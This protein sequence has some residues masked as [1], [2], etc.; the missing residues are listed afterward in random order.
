MRTSSIKHSDKPAQL[1]FSQKP[2]SCFAR[3]NQRE[4][5]IALISMLLLFVMVVTLS[6]GMIKR[7]EL[8]MK[9][10]N[11]TLQRADLREV[12]LGIEL[13]IREMIL[14]LLGRA[15]LLGQDKELYLYFNPLGFFAAP[16]QIPN[17]YDV[18]IHISDPQG[19]LNLNDLAQEDADRKRAA[20]TVLRKLLSD[21]NFE[22][23]NGM[24]EEAKR[25][26]DSDLNVNDA[27]Y[28]AR[29]IP[30]KAGHQPF[31]TH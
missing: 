27:E 15:K 3:F 5:G 7:Q 2:R 14:S 17:E 9:R 10:A 6:V 26:V 4:S 25:W 8:T 22:D 23:P 29:E 1:H 31:K 18:S 28:E 12:A 30:H 19:K 16:M 11:N 13:S 20:E 24:V 21:L